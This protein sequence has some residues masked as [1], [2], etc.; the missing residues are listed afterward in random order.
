[1]E[2]ISTPSYTWSKTYCLLTK[3]RI[4]MGNIITAS[5]GFALASRGSFNILLLLVTFLG[6]SLVIA[7]ACV[8]NNYID[9]NADKKMAR[10]KNRP[11]AAGLISPRR[12]ILFAIF[13]GT[14]GIF[15]LAFF[16]NPLTALLALFGFLVYV[17]LYSFSK[18]YS[19]HGTLIGSV[20]GAMPPVIGYCAVSGHLSIGA[21]ILFAM[22]TI[23]QMPHFFAIA[24]NQMKDYAAASIPVLPIKRGMLNTK[25]QMLLYIIVFAGISSLLTVF[26]YTG[27]AYLAVAMPLCLAWLWLCIKGFRCNNDKIWARKMFACSLV[28]VIGI[29]LAIPFTVC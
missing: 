27:N 8:F 6:L 28:V 26:K 9:R 25:I 18:Y 2:R 13:L 19:V 20:A 7:S 21:L 29:S 4:I 10:T 3:P 16:A 12:A 15:L 23:W 22:I 14:L 17:L 1:M 5:A 24:I 11:L